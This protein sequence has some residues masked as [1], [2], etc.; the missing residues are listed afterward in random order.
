MQRGVDAPAQ[1]FRLQHFGRVMGAG[2]APMRLYLKFI[3]PASTV[4]PQLRHRR[5]GEPIIGGMTTTRAVIGSGLL[6]NRKQVVT[7][8]SPA[9]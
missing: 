8:R 5:A 7:G 2:G 4:Q 9:R 3:E 6:S 1:G